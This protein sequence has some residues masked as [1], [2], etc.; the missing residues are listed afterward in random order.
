MRGPQGS[1]C[2][3]CLNR[4]SSS[5]EDRS[6][7]T[8]WCPDGYASSSEGIC[9]DIYACDTSPCDPNAV[10]RDV[11]AADIFSGVSWNPPNSGDDWI[12]SGGGVEGRSCV[13]DVG[14]RG[15]GEICVPSGS[16]DTRTSQSTSSSNTTSSNATNG[17]ES[18]MDGV[19]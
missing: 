1:K 6:G 5:P 19:I 17:P 7:R 16:S 9:E 15:D 10:C 3:V 2:A 13:C 14:F 8:C 12:P 18:P 11:K 4:T